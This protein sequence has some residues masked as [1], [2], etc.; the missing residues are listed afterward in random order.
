MDKFMVL[1]LP[2]DLSKA[3]NYNRTNCRKTS[4]AW[5]CFGCLVGCLFSITDLLEKMIETS[6]NQEC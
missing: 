1:S 2:F 5:R 6:S 3:L 4:D